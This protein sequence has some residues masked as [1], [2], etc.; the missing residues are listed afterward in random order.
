[1]QICKINFSRRVSIFTRGRLYMC[2]VHLPNTKW[3]LLEIACERSCKL[4]VNKISLQ[5]WDEKRAACVQYL[6][7]AFS[8]K[9][10]IEGVVYLPVNDE[11]T[12]LKFGTTYEHNWCCVPKPQVT[13]KQELLQQLQHNNRHIKAIAKLISIFLDVAHPRT[14]SRA[15]LVCSHVAV[16]VTKS[17]LLIC[18]TSARHRT[19][20]FP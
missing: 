12:S 2:R 5:K 10:H 18:L 9:K 16:Y 4:C 7:K 15:A 14:V 1:M 19:I 13:P 6:L 20:L 11:I 3:G 17:R 8:S